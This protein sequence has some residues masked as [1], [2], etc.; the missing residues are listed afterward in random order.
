MSV[1]YKMS[2]IY[3]MSVIY[4]MK[5]LLKVLEKYKNIIANVKKRIN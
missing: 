1:I 3:K 2:F 5:H 4:K